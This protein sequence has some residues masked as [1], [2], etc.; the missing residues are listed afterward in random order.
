MFEFYGAYR[1][2]DITKEGFMALL[3]ILGFIGHREP[4][5][6]LPAYP[7]VKFSLVAGFRQVPEEWL[8]PLKSFLRGESK[9]FLERAVMALVEKPYARHHPD[10]IQEFLDA[11]KRFYKFEAVPLRRAM[12]AN[13][14]R[15]S[16]LPQA[17][18]DRIFLR[19]R[20]GREDPQQSAQYV[21]L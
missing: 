14:I 15:E 18:R 13:G 21:N 17:D 20:A 11:L 19:S 9:E 1:S 6:K 12:A 10:E 5:K 16:F 4:A 8:V 7:R 2:R 3:E